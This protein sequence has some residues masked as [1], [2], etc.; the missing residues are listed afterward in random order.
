MAKYQ[1]IIE[2]LRKRIVEGDFTP[3]HRLPSQHMLMRQ[4]GVSRATVQR[5]LRELQIGGLLESRIGSGSY[6]TSF[7]HERRG[8]LGIIAPDYRRIEYFT[9]LCDGISK[10]ANAAGYDIF[11]S[12]AATPD[13]ASRRSWSR[14]IAAEYVER[15]VVGAFVE[16]VDLVAKSVDATRETLALFA[17]R[18]IPVILL[19][20]DYLPPPDRSGYDIVGNDNIQGAYRLTRHLINRGARRICFAT[21]SDYANTIANRIQGMMLALNDAGLPSGR[22]QVLETDF[23]DVDAFAAYMRRRGAP[24]AFICRNDHLAGRL[25]RVL[26][27]LGIEVPGKVRVAGFDDSELSRALRPRL[28]SVR[29]DQ[30]QI[31][32]A[33]FAAMMQRIADRALPPRT[34]YVNAPLIVRQST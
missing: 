17:E 6:I 25:L 12:V 34:I 23:S 33:A 27:K 10:L 13:P 1:D 8:A 15:G 19:D 11:L 5:A 26:A 24:D 30:S 32:A 4:Y 22:N 3:D 7:A 31:A 18:N 20:R 21:Q 28:T 29:L 14:G 2:E 9:G 16:P